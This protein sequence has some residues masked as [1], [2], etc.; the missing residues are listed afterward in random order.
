MLQSQVVI[1]KMLN[2]SDGTQKRICYSLLAMM[3]LLSVGGMRI[4][5]MT[6]SVLSLLKVMNLQSGV[7]FLKLIN[8]IEV[9]FDRTG[10][11]MVSCGEDKNWMIWDI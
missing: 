4:Q 6:G 1:H 11:Y 10:R 3:T 8:N 5:L 7:I 9:D 2:M